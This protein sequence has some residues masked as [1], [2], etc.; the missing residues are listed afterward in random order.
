MLLQSTKPFPRGVFILGL[1]ATL[2]ICSSSSW[3]AGT[4]YEYDSLGRL[5]TVTYN[6]GDANETIVEYHYDP[7]DNRR[8]VVVDGST[9]GSPGGGGSNQAPTLEDPADRTGTVDVPAT[10]TLNGDDPDN[11]P[12]SLT[13]SLV[14]VS[15]SVTPEPSVSGNVLSWTPPSAGTYIVTVRVSDGDLTADQSFTWTINAVSGGGG[16]DPYASNRLAYWDM[17]QTS[18]STVVDVEGVSSGATQQG[19]SLNAAGYQGIGSGVSLD[20]IDDVV[21]I[22]HHGSFKP[23]TGSLSLWVKPDVIS[24]TQGLFSKDHSGNGQ[25]GHLTVT[26][27]GDGRIR[28]RLQSTSGETN[29]YST[30]VLS[31]GAWYHVVAS[32]GSSGARLHV[33]GAQEASD[34]GFTTGMGSSSGGTG[35]DEPIT[36]GAS[37]DTS[38]PLSSTP[39]RNWLDGTLDEVSLYDVQVDGSALYSYYTSGG[40]PG[41][42]GGNTPPSLNSPGPQNGAVGDAVSLTLNASDPDS[43]DTLS[44]SASGLPAG[45]SLNAGSGVISGVLTTEGSFSVTASVSDGTNPAVSQTFTWTVNAAP[46]GGA[47]AT[48]TLDDA[49]VE[50]GTTEWQPLVQNGSGTATHAQGTARTGSRSLQLN[51]NGSLVLVRWMLREAPMGRITVVSGDTV[52]ASAYVRSEN[53]SGVSRLRVRFFPSVGNWSEISHSQT[54]STTTLSTWTKLEHCA[55]APSSGGVGRI[56]LHQEGSGTSYFDDVFIC[57]NCSATPN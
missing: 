22:P 14:S 34:G 28:M 23:N 57:K 30:T 27:E 38:G 7:S 24:G 51:A 8:M 44:F 4:Q 45:L 53:Q 25:G 12:S 50:A 49:S 15:P 37:Q 9:G 18:G 35:N 21:E 2:V 40:G 16:P 46:G 41:G 55:T 33:D 26:V 54:E 42:G 17:T 29:L 36:L 20:G 3:A 32:W 5:I 6:A 52:C 48:N 31:A 56:E 39:L 10:V 11:G 43:S 1:V 13:Y 47:G 19:A